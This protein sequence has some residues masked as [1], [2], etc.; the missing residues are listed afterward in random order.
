MR[1]QLLKSFGDT[2]DFQ[3]ADIP[4]PAVTPGHVLVRVAAS[5]VNPIDLKIR[6]LRPAFAPQ[7][8]AVLGM[9]MAGVVEAVG[10]GVADFA[11]GDAVFGCVGGV[12]GLQGTLAE[13]VSA[14]ARLL[15]RKPACLSMVQAAALPLVTITAWL[16]LFDRARIQPGQRVLIHAGA[17]GVGHVAVQ[18]ARAF[19]ARVAATVSGPEKAA[20]AE[21]FGAQDIVDYRRE[22]V[23]A[24]VERLTGGQG[25]DA[26]FDTV[27]G[28][29][30]DD[31]LRAA[32][33]GGTVV[34]INTRSTHDLSPLHAKGLTLS[35]VFMLLPLVTGQG[36][37]RHGEILRRAAA[38]AEEGKLTPLLAARRFH[39][40]EAA[41]AH[42]YLDSGQAVGKV[43]VEVA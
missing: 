7:L 10:D 12:A 18:L 6:K 14:D 38:L 11:P 22:S 33:A 36:R 4:V 8:P 2:P 21:R 5:G 15:A 42:D 24:C 9:D 37:E 43:V 28:K 3:A 35:V 41:Q 29:T 16:A 31:S 1:A 39:L 25:F 27:G 32:R 20:L 40:E 30:L 17:G 19:G 13:Y 23:E 26:V 34:S